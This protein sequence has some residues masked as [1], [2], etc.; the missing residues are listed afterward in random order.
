MSGRP[1]RITCK[2]EHPRITLLPT[3]PNRPPALCSL[4][5]LSSWRSSDPHP[6]DPVWPLGVLGRNLTPGQASVSPFTVGRLWERPPT[7][8]PHRPLALGPP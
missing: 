7:H 2:P 8:W 5:Q 6:Q 4:P 1:T 3:S